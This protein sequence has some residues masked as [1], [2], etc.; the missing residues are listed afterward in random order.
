MS[1]TIARRCLIEGR[2]QGVAFRHYTKVRARE[3]GLVGWVQNRADGRVET[4]LEGETRPVEELVAW[5][6]KGPPTARVARVDVIEE[7]PAGHVRFEVRR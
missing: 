5:L 3:L 2:V 1:P 4:W 6:G 7:E